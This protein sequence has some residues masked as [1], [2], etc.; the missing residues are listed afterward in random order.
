MAVAVQDVELHVV[1]GAADGQD[2]RRGRR[3][4]DHVP[5]GGHGGL[6]GPVGVDEESLPLEPA[7]AHLGGAGLPA[8]H[9]CI[10]GRVLPLGQDGQEGGGEGQVADGVLL[11]VAFQIRHGEQGLSGG[12]V[13]GRPLDQGG[14]DLSHRA[15]EAQGEELQHSFPRRQAQPQGVVADQVG[16]PSMF[17]EHALGPAS[18]T[19][20]V[21]DVGQVVR[22]HRD[23]WRGGG[24]LGDGGP[25]RVQADDGDWRLEIGD[26]ELFGQ[27]LLG[28]EDRGLGL[29]QHELETGGR[30]AR[31]QGEVGAPGFEHPQDSHHHLR[32]ALQGDAHRCLWPHASLDQEV[33]QLVGLGLHLRVGEAASFVPEGRGLGGAGRLLLDELVDGRLQGVVRGRLVPGPQDLPRLLWGEEMEVPHWASGIPGHAGQELL[34]MPQ[35]ALDGLGLEAAAIVEDLEQQLLVR[36]GDEVQGV[37]GLL[38]GGHVLDGQ[39]ALGARLL[40][41]A[42]G[43]V[44]LED[45]DALEEGLLPRHIAPAVDAHQ[46]AVLVLAQLHQVILEAAQ[47][48]AHGQI[49]L[50]LGPNRQGVDEEADHELRAGQ[51]RGAAGD[52]GAE[53]HVLLTAV[54]AEEQSPGPVDQGAQGHALAA[55]QSLQLLGELPGEDP[56]H[57]FVALG[58]LR[59]CRPVHD[60]GGGGLEAGQGLPP[61]AFGLAHVL[62]AQPDDVVPVGVGRGQVG[63]SAL[64]EG[65]VPGEDLLHEDGRRPAVQKNVVM[66][67]DEAV[68]V[69]AGAGQGEAHEGRLG[70]L[71]SPLALFGDQGLQAS[72]LLFRGESPQVQQAQGRLHLAV[73]HLDGLLQPFPGEAGAQDGVALDRPLPGLAEGVQVQGSSQGALEQLHI[74]AGFRRQQAVE[75]H[76][77][78]HGG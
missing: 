46:G 45:Q 66:S 65:L 34:Q 14:E 43:G 52:G 69:V 25:V 72:R 20:G 22:P 11:Q 63:R 59:V 30:V 76:A 9:H 19:R 60:E 70:Q 67:P 53:E 5:G 3:L 42:G 41:G 61:E 10:Q 58:L 32:R 55:A 56:V 62:A 51:V 74:D 68:G 6:R 18:G 49:R 21:D 29:L 48:V 75:E 4:L 36:A 50:D 35:H 27:A 47:P 7:A 64:G 31:V 38:D 33:G 57:L 2:P 15:V 40:E 12:Q 44:V 24:L 28:E 26:W 39:A 1:Q 23:R 73:H 37:V 8:H 78:L 77:L 17:Q 13:E 54:A 16:Q 71:E